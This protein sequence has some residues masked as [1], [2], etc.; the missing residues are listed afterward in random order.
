SN[1]EGNGEEAFVNDESS[2]ETTDSSEN[3]TSSDKDNS[4]KTEEEKFLEEQKKHLKIGNNKVKLTVADSW[5]RSTT[6]ERDLFIKNG[7]D[8]NEII[9]KSGSGQVPIRIKFNH[10]TKN[11]NITT[12][13]IKFSN[14]SNPDYV[15]IAVYRPNENDSGATPIFQEISINASDTVTDRTLESLKNYRFEYGDYFEIYHGHPQ[16]FYITGG[17][18]DQREDYT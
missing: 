6:I 3:G 1:T 9:F 4:N 12:Q 2:S 16:L 8:K 17:I 14:T 5:G 10:E 13:N 18:N 7:I 11:L 15:K